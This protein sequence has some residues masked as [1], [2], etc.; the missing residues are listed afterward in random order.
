MDRISLENNPFL[1]AHCLKL[2]CFFCC[3]CWWWQ[4]KIINWSLLPSLLPPFLM[5]C[6]DLRVFPLNVSICWSAA[7]RQLQSHNHSVDTC[8]LRSIKS[9]WLRRMASKTDI[10]DD[11]PSVP[12][13]PY[14]DGEQGDTGLM[15]LEQSWTSWWSWP[16]VIDLGVPCP[17]SRAASW[18]RRSTD[19]N[20]LER[21][22]L[23]FVLI[24]TSR[25]DVCSCVGGGGDGCCSCLWMSFVTSTHEPGHG[26]EVVC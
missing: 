3:C 8:R 19:F 4:L 18:R 20:P 2:N 5:D 17:D 10:G 25:V 26:K 14:P 15:L 23:K 24:W 9:S 12:T 21:A 6:P 11:S 1:N 13:I 22:S 7:A 16:V